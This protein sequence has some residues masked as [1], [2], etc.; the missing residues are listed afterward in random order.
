MQAPDDLSVV[1]AL[2]WGQVL[3]L[4][5]D[6][7]LARAVLNTMLR[8]PTTNEPFWEQV[9]QML[10]RNA[11]ISSEEVV[12]FVGFIH[13]QRFQPARLVL[14][15]GNEE[16]PLQPDFDIRGQT[17]RSLRRHMANWQ[18]ERRIRLQQEYE[19]NQRPYVS[20]WV[21]TDIQPFRHA[22]NDRYWTIEELLSDI[23]LRAEG[24]I[25]QHCVASYTNRCAHRQ[26]SIWSMKLHEG[27]RQKRILTIEVDPKTRQI[28]Q[29]KGR[30]NTA[31]D[32]KSKHI[33]QQWA[34]EAGLSLE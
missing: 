33:L 9:I 18:E 8:S 28:R 14:R 26:S 11:P 7:K 22:E 20:Q 29:A 16:T 30:R 10:A 24:G 27:Q 6:K 4:G 34:K 19:R 2:R 15:R 13:Q 17:L 31:P 3:G 25:M 1:Q 5:G 21:T 12:Q 32:G 23:E